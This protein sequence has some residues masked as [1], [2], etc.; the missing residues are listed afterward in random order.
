MSYTNRKDLTRFA[1]LSIAAALATI[2]LKLSAFWL[3]NSVGLL[4]DAMESVVNLVAAVVALLA[5]Q[6]AARPADDDFSFG[7]TKA[8]F[9]ASGFEGTMILVA[10]GSIAI[11]AIPRL[12]NPQPLEQVGLGLAISSVAAVINLVVSRVLTS[13]GKRYHSI[14]LVADARHLMTDVVTTIGVFVGVGLV[15]LTGWV[16]L[17]PIIALLVA[18]NIL[19]TGIGLVRHSAL[20]LMD[21]ALPA[22]D[23]QEI[24]KALEKFDSANIE[25]HA[26]RSRS[27][28]ARG[29]VSMHILVPGD[30]TIQRGHDLAEEVEKEI[31]RRLPQIH[32]LTHVE[33]L[34]DPASW[35]DTNLNGE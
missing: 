6:I 29:F 34:E 11:T 35:S 8:E 22:N 1:W 7:Y 17:D 13:A 27:A 3:T 14:A 9:F 19:I 31:T 23:M 5:L 28:A 15:A 10:A 30:W 24:Q 25:F 4:S 16:I 2:F 32:V 33:P 26:L 20:G 21:A 18:L 12:T